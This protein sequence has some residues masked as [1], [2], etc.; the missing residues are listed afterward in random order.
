MSDKPRMFDLYTTIGF[1]TVPTFNLLLALALVAGGGV[2]V[3][4]LRDRYPFAALT[5]CGL[6]GLVGGVVG[7]RVGH[8]LLNWHYFSDHSDEITRLSVGGLDWHGALIGGLLGI[9]VVSRWRRV[10]FAPL[11]DALTP[12]LPLLT[13]GGWLGCAVRHVHCAYGVEVETLALYPPLLVVESPDVYGIIAPRYN[14]HLFG[15]LLA[16]VTL[17]LVGW[18]FWRDRLH[19]RRFW[20]VLALLSAGMFVI[21]LYRADSVLHVGALRADQLLD[22]AF[23]VVAAIFSVQRFVKIH[24]LTSNV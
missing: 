19:G 18:L 6:G 17:V 10:A 21:G 2:A 24:N 3:Y 9:W 13:L 22:V 4:H 8:V 15:T 7:A 23:M 11:L 5:D 1:L 12:L 16:L 20:L 14:T